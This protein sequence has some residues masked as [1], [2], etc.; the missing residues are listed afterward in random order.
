[1]AAARI[2]ATQA[3]A[4]AQQASPALKGR[5]HI[6]MGK[7]ELASERFTEAEHEFDRVLDID[8][9]NPIAR[10]GKE[11]ARDAAAKAKAH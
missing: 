1:M 2:T 4:A 11:R 8:P 3:V 10:K 5:A 6:I 9:Q 7:V